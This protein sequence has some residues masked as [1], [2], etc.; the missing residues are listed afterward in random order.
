MAE[1]P[2]TEIFFVAVAVA[3][4]SV[5]EQV[6]VIVPEAPP[7]GTAVRVV[8]LLVELERLIPVVNPLND[9]V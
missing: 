1:E 5:A 7:V 9:H 3:A 2:E 8:G 4:R 6:T